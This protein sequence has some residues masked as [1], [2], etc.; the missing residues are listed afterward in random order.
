MQN[1]NKGKPNEDL[2]GG[3]FKNGSKDMQRESG[4]RKERTDESSVKYQIQVPSVFPSI[5]PDRENHNDQIKTM[6][7]FY[8]SI[9]HPS[10]INK[11]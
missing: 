2:I 5:D 1:I 3:Y 10:E 11:S 7:N 4:Q 9:L 8:P 6:T